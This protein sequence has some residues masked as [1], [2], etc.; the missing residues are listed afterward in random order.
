MYFKIDLCWSVVYW[1]CYFSAR[2]VNTYLQLMLRGSVQQGTT[3]WN[4]QV[5][6]YCVEQ[7]GLSVK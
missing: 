2:Q 5:E 3:W 6:M 1:H 4:V 7:T